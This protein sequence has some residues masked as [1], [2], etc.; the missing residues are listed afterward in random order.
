MK[1]IIERPGKMG[2]G[3]AYRDGLKRASGQFVII[4]DADLS[5]HPKFIPS[6]VAY[7]LNT[8]KDTKRERC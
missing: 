4:M 6:M 3:S 5:H 8:L 1:V 7:L 2:L